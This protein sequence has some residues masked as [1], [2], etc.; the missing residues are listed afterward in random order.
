MLGKEA[1][2]KL[3]KVPCLGGLNDIT[4]RVFLQTLNSVL[5]LVIYCDSLGLTLR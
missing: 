1:A 4:F 5:D 3:Q 2:K